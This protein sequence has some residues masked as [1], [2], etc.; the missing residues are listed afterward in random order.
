[1]K[2]LIQKAFDQSLQGTNLQLLQQSLRFLLF[3]YSDVIK[4]NFAMNQESIQALVF[5]RLFKCLMLVTKN[6][7]AHIEII[8]LRMGFQV[9][10]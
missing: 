6:L 10:I 7:I 1:M 2:C 3:S 5:N 8:I 4:I 9:K